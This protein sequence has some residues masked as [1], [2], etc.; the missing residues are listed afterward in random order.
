M[1]GV[2][3]AGTANECG[4][5]ELLI[6]SPT[7]ASQ[8]TK[9]S[10]ERTWQ[11]TLLS[12]SFAKSSLMVERRAVSM[13]GQTNAQVD[14]GPIVALG[15]HDANPVPYLLPLA[16]SAYIRIISIAVEI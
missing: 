16:H 7:G 3:V 11:C 6:V 2:P 13:P 14:H 4:L 5:R 9:R 1:E 12:S 15:M 8:P 10:S